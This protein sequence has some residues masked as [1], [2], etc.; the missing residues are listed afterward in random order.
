MCEIQFINNEFDKNKIFSFQFMHLFSFEFSFKKIKKSNRSKKYCS[1]LFLLA[2]LY[3]L[4][5]KFIFNKK[6]L[7]KN[8]V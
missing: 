8:I 5:K 1:L 3:V 2:I 4:N 6:T 7:L